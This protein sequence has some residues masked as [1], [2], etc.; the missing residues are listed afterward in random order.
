MKRI[1]SLLLAAT[2]VFCFASC[3]TVKLEGVEAPIDILNTVWASYGEA[4]TFFAMGGDYN[5]M[6]ENAPG[7]VDV[8]DTA[9][10]QDLL[11][12]P[13]HAAGMIDGVASLIHAMNANTFTGAAYHIAD[14]KNA[15]E[16]I[17]AMQDSI[18]SKQ[19]VCG[20]PEQLLIAKLSADYVVVAYGA[21]DLVNTFSAKLTAAYATTE[22]VV[23][24]AM[25]V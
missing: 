14:G 19:W 25:T 20:T 7:V 21:A 16:F 8:T 22:A 13:E 5:N 17:T 4:E 6:V 12:C 9:T 15:D 23:N 18:A 11:T 2:M 1:L 10:L 3:G 24:E